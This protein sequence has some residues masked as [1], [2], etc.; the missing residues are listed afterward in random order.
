MVY[1]SNYYPLMHGTSS[2]L[3]LGMRFGITAIITRT[4]HEGCGG[5]GPTGKLNWIMD[6][7]HASLPHEDIPTLQHQPMQNIRSRWMHSVGLF[8][9]MS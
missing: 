8:V 3:V 5:A 6:A 2:R 4:E 9:I 7:P 1:V